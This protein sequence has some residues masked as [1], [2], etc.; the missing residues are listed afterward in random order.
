MSVILGEYFATV[1]TEENLD[2]L[3]MPSERC[4][5]GR[6]VCIEWIEVTEEKAELA[7]GSLKG[8]KAAGVD[9]IE[10]NYVKRSMDGLVR[11]LRRI[12]HHHHHQRFLSAL[13]VDP[14]KNQISRDCPREHRFDITKQRKEKST[15]NFNLT[16]A[17]VHPNS[18]G[19]SEHPHFS[20][21]LGQLPFP[22]AFPSSSSPGPSSHPK[23]TSFF[24]YRPP[25]KPPLVYSM[26]LVLHKYLCIFISV[27]DCSIQ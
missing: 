21:H 22:P 14:K 10:S 6:N 24:L 2:T 26:K 15:N 13:P 9:E 19:D 20:K 1:F 7:I 18:W 11:P 5:E 4:R 25:L 8:N 27:C 3:P 16:P 12:Y 17:L 23:Y